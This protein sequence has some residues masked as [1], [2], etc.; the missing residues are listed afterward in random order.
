MKLLYTYLQNRDRKPHSMVIPHSGHAAFASYKAS[1]NRS[2]CPFRCR[3]GNQRAGFGC[4]ISGDCCMSLSYVFRRWTL[5][6]S[7]KSEHDTH[8][9]KT[10]CTGRICF[11]AVRVEVEVEEILI[12]LSNVKY[13]ALTSSTISNLFYPLTPIGPMEWITLHGPQIIGNPG[14]TSDRIKEKEKRRRKSPLLEITLASSM[15]R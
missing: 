2:W 12:G 7:P 14:R 1:A 3:G 5:T 15:D 4:C 10:R 9:R 6:E 13:I 11:Q 8:R